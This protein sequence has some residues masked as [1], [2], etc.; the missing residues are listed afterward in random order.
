MLQTELRPTRRTRSLPF[1]LTKQKKKEVIT[2]CREE[3]AGQLKLNLSFDFG[4]KAEAGSIF[5]SKDR[6]SPKVSTHPPSRFLSLGCSAGFVPSLKV[7]NGSRART[8]DRT[9]LFGQVR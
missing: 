1:T 6:R 9:F 8:G 3:L 7:P 4:R 2:S 5:I